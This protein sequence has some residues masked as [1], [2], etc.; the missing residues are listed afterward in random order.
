M[1]VRR[2][3]GILDLARWAATG[4]DA[5]ERRRWGVEGAMIELTKQAGE[6]ARHDAGRVLRGQ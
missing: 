6:L 4:F 3:D 5:V 1:G 2:F